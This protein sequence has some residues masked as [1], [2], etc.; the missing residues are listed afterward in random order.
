[1]KSYLF[2]LFALI[3][4]FVVNSGSAREYNILDFGAKADTAFLS[5]QAI[6][7]AID[8]CSEAG[9]GT[10]VIPAGHFKTG[11]IFL[12]SNVNFYLESGA[13]LFGSRD[14]KDY[15][16]IKPGYISLRT[17]EATIQLIY[18]EDATNVSITGYGTIDGQGRSFK[19]L[20][21]NDEG[22]TRP[23]L[24]RFITCRNVL[25]EN[26]SLR[27]SGCWMQHYLACDEVQI[28]G[29]KVF[30]RNNYN[31]DGLD[32]DGCH[33]VTVSDF[34]SDSDDD[35][36]TLKS[37]S[38]RACENIAITNCV[39]SSRCNAIKMGTESNGGF[40]N[41][42]ISNCVVKPSPIKEPTFYGAPTGSSAIS[43]EIVDGGK[44][45]G[46]SINNIQVEGTE[47]PIFI[48]LGNRARSHKS[49]VTIDHVGEISDVSISHVRVKTEGNTA[50]SITGQ[51]GFPVRNVRLNDI[52]VESAGGG[53]L[54][55]FQCPV[56]YKPKDYPE[57]T[58]FGVLPAYGFYLRH[59]ENIRFDNCAFV[60]K[61]IDARPAVFIEKSVNCVLDAL[62][63]TNLKTETEAGIYASQVQKL[64]VK[65]SIGGAGLKTLVRVSKQ[66]E[67]E[68][69]LSGNVL[70][71]GVLELETMK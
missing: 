57:A 53:T 28:R 29:V 32:L 31:N 19:K 34:I 44:M 21:K 12:K 27:N 63:L 70:S 59:A 60:T 2:V 17:Q 18:A 50:C 42:T 23:H 65:G 6:Q 67:S 38:P 16:K 54:A 8:Q 56:E 7:Q 64:I 11:S 66:D 49:G 1:M 47:A 43:L 22:I 68:I 51:P 55:D 48:R 35:G 26:I 52:I 24:L 25:V 39:I 62:D 3:G 46:I 5:T 13:V 58:M 37:T 69:T 36:V 71:D 45:E 14:L 40:R 4:L 30:N 15:T 61:Q 9:G 41:I 20:T 10:V 33:D